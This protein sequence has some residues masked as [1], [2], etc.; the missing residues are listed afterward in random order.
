MTVKCKF[1]C[2][3]EKLSIIESFESMQKTQADICR[4]M[5]FSKSTV[6]T[7]V[8]ANRSKIKAAFL[9][10][11]MVQWFNI[12]EENDKGFLQRF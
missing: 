7:Y 6:A 3:S 9:D 12:Q 5:D 11:S 10:G 8:V 4:E 2:L 1:I